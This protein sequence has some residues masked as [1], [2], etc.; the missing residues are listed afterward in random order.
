NYPLLYFTDSAKDAWTI[1]DAVRGTQIFGGIGS[2]K[3]SSSGRQ[4]AKSMLSNG[5]GGLVLCSKPDEKSNWVQYA[6]ET[7]REKSLKILSEHGEYRFNFLDY[8]MNRPDGGGL[9]RNISNLFMN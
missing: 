7:G 1:S 5:F 9:T 2:G 8:E 3:S 6:K 4:I